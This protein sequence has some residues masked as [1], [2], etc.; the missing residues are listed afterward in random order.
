MI[1]NSIVAPVLVARIQNNRS[2]RA[3][4][5]VLRKSMN[6]DGYRLRVLF[7]GPRSPETGTV[8]SRT[9]RKDA[10]TFRVYLDRIGATTAQAWYQSEVER[11]RAVVAR[12]EGSVA[13]RQAIIE[14][15]AA[16]CEWYRRESARLNADSVQ[17]QSRTADAEAFAA[18]ARRIA[19]R[20]LVGEIT[21]TRRLNEVP[22]W[23]LYIVGAARSLFQ[24]VEP[25][26]LPQFLSRFINR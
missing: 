21:A 17:L 13:E 26:G 1:Q 25:V 4:L 19:S 7:S 22:A 12:L 9:L 5:D 23:V 15:D 2:G 11:L 24:P 6:R 10:K 18:E 16:D 14:R 8:F 20:A 3:A